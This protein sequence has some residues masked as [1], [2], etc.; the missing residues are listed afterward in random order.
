MNDGPDVTTEPGVVLMFGSGE[1]APSGRRALTWLFK[2]L[3]A[4]PRMSILETPAGF[5]PNSAQVAGKVADFVRERLQN[6]DPQVEVIGARAR[7]SNASPDD[8]ALLTP[9]L[10]ADLLYLGAGSPTY[11]VRHLR[12]TVAWQ[13]LVGRH[14]LG[15]SVVLASASMLAAGRMTLPVYEI[16]KVGLPLHWIDG[17]DLLGPF[18]LSLVPVP[19]WNNVDGGAGLDTSRCYMGQARF[20]RLLELLSPEQVV[21]GVDEHTALAID[22]AQERCVVLG[23]GSVTLVRGGSS[24]VR[25]SGSDFPIQDLGPFRRPQPAANLPAALWQTLV[26]AAAVPAAAAPPE[27]VRAW[28]TAREAARE[29]GEWDAADALRERIHS[30]GWQVSDTPDGPRLTPID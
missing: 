15:A 14:R 25:P 13:R 10:T 20:D 9:L 3:P 26:T 5:E 8:P 4:A 30:L 12:D 6:F 22:P 18:G 27:Q 21:V 16:Y 11:T 28:A 2:R 29:T 23:N 24:S 19:H 17:L 1:T 7:D